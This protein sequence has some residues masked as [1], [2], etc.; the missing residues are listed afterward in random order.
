MINEARI[1]ATRITYACVLRCYMRTS[2]TNQFRIVELCSSVPQ[3][4]SVQFSSLRNIYERY[5]LDDQILTCHFMSK[6]T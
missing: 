1:T 2:S 4:T 5:R 6:F 3:F